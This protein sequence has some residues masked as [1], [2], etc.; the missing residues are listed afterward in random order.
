MQIFPIVY[1]VCFEFGIETAS[2]KFRIAIF[3]YRIFP[4]LDETAV[5]WCLKMRP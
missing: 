3:L 2:G 4:F 1:I 5:Q